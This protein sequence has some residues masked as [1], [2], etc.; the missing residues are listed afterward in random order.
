MTV[1]V[2][3]QTNTRLLML[4]MAC[5]E[6]VLEKPYGSTSDKTAVR[7]IQ[8]SQ[9]MTEFTHSD[10]ANIGDSAVTSHIQRSQS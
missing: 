9:V 10:D 5:G 1:L 8:R 2:Y 6:C 7:D 4:D 3:V